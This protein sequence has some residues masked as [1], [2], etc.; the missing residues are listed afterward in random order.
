M[1]VGKDKIKGPPLKDKGD[2]KGDL[3]VRDLWIQRTDS[4]HDMCVMNIDATSYQ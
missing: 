2:L 3:L 1:R 4:I